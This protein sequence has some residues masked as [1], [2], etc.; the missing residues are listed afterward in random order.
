V[1]LLQEKRQPFGCLNT[2]IYSVTVT[3]QATSV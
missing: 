1:P 3:T 2:I